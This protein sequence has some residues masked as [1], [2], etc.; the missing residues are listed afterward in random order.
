MRRKVAA[1][2]GTAP[3]EEAP[4]EPETGTTSAAAPVPAPVPRPRYAESDAEK[5]VILP[6]IDY[7]DYG[8]G[9]YDAITEVMPAIRDV[10]G[11]SN[12]HGQLPYLISSRYGPGAVDHG[13]S[14]PPAAT[15][16]C[17]PEV[18]EST[19]KE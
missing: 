12:A 9:P 10:P 6:R 2:R 11:R 1:L 19:T 4:S 15:R 18:D 5:T 7:G 17:T 8:V 14:R 16:V 3:V 13:S